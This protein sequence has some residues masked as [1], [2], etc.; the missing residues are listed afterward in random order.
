MFTQEIFV[1]DET[2]IF[3]HPMFNLIN[4]NLNGSRN[5]EIH[6]ITQSL[7]FFDDPV[8]SLLTN[9]VP[10]SVAVLAEHVTTV[11]IIFELPVVTEQS[12]K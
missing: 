12:W 6:L 7:F 8:P 9:D 3:N 11:V 4:W 2:W 10:S 1:D 5:R